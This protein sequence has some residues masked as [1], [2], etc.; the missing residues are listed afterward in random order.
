MRQSWPRHSRVPR[1]L[2]ER[3]G[4]SPFSLFYRRRRWSESEQVWMG[5]ERKRGKLEDLNRMLVGANGAENQGDADHSVSMLR[6][7]GAPARLMRFR[8]V[9]T[10]DDDT[11]LPRGAAKSMIATLAHPLN[12]PR[13]AEDGT[14]V[15][16]GYTIIQPRVN[17]A[18]PS[19]TAT[20]FSRI[21]TDARG[22]DPYTL[23]VSDVY[24]DL[25]GEGSYHG[26][27][28]YDLQMF[29]HV[30]NRRFPE[31][32]ILSHD[33]LEGAYVR[34]GF[35][36]DIEV[37]DSF[38]S[39]YRAYSRRQHRWVRGDWQIAAWCA[40]RVPTRNGWVVNPLT[41]INRWK[42]F[43]NLRRSLIPAASLALLLLG[44]IFLPDAALVW[45]GIVVAVLIISAVLQLTLW[46]PGQSV[47]ALAAW[48]GWRGWREIAPTWMRA[49]LSA[50]AMP[51]QAAMGLDAIVRVIFRRL[52]SHRHL[53]E[54]Q[55]SQLRQASTA[56]YRAPTGRANRLDHS[57]V[58]N[59]TGRD[60]SKFSG[61]TLVSRS[62]L[63]PLVMLTRDFCLARRA[64][65]TTTR[66]GGS[67]VERGEL[68]QLAR[69]T[70]RFFDD[71]V[72]PES[73]WLPPDNFQVALRVETARRTSPTNIG[74][75][76]LSSLT[77]NDFGYVTLDDLVQRGLATLESLQGLETF[78][79]H[80]LNWYDTGTLEPLY[81][82]L[83]L[84]RR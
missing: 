18:L 2:N 68:R 51:Q 55:T 69:Q 47:A 20:R 36:S 45:S 26:K 44:W 43:D 12:R 22:T 42:I 48:R 49:G 52:I 81:P 72:G 84:H 56:K 25:F 58:G 61:R 8:S 24:Q 59:G 29:H 10:L 40:P 50:A 83:C 65:S 21:F 17:T 28:I 30:L 64:P 35:A 6:H 34:A 14:T 60:R 13:L 73:N 1:T 41:L 33:L 53:L 19:A 3:Y 75:G 74:L 32:S 57:D 54:W 63:D 76:L 23:A 7:D 62:V 71:L 11:D 79:G 31:E 67:T 37:F 77:A 9:I 46:L 38:P 16:G 5:W 82:T 78:E 39:S 66:K 27:G 15:S 70:W 80:I 4:G